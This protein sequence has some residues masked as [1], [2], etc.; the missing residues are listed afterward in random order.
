MLRTNA[1]GKPN[2]AG[3]I[4]RKTEWKGGREEG[5]KEGNLF[6]ARWVNRLQADYQAASKEALLRTT[7][8]R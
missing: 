4:V 3:A 2:K 7:V 1:S 6:T 8:S 5:S